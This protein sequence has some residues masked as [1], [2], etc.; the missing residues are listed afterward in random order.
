MNRRL[1][2]LLALCALIGC[3]GETPPAGTS[4]GGTDA[5]GSNGGSTTGESGSDGSSSTGSTTGTSSS[6]TSGSTTASSTATASS[7]G[8][9]SASSASGSSGRSSS[10]GSSASSSTAASSG[11]SGRSSSSSS[12][13]AGSSGSSGRSSSSGSTGSGTTG[14]SSGSSGGTGSTGC[15]SESNATFCSRLNR[16]C[17]SHTANDNCGVRRTVADCGSCTGTDVCSAGVCSCPGETNTAFCSRVGA[18]CGQVS[19]TDICG[20][21]RT[22][23]S[24]GSCTSP[25]SCGG[26]G[27]ANQCG[28]TAE[29]DAEFCTAKGKACG[30]VAGT[31]RCGR[32]RNITDCGACTSP[33][34]CGGGTTPGQC[35]CTAESNTTFCARV[36]ATCGAVTAADNCG[37]SRTVTSC[38]SCTSPATCDTQSHTCGCTGQTDAELCATAGRGC[39]ALTTT[40]RCGATRTIA[41]CGS[42]DPNSALCGTRGRSEGVCLARTPLPAQ[43]VCQTTTGLCWKAPAPTPV[44]VTDVHTEADGTAWA[45]SGNTVI[46]WDGTKFRGFDSVGPVNAYFAAV[47][48]NGPSDV[49]V[50]GSR[51]LVMHFDGTV[52]EDLSPGLLASGTDI[53]DVTDLTGR[54]SSEVWVVGERRQSRMWNGTRW[55][56]PIG[57]TFTSTSGTYRQVA[58]YSPTELRLAT[59]SDLLSWN[60]TTITKI[61]SISGVQHLA[62]G[63]PGELWVASSTYSSST[64]SYRAQLSKYVGGTPSSASLP[65][66]GLANGSDLFVAPRA[67]D[68]IWLLDTGTNSWQFDGNAWRSA[69][70]T[71][72]NTLEQFSAASTQAATSLACTW[73]GGWA[74][75]TSAGWSRLD[76]TFFPPGIT[77]RLETLQ[78]VPLSNGRLAMT[79][80]N[81]YPAP[82]TLPRQVGIFDG[83]NWTG[84][85]NINSSLA[86]LGSTDG[87]TLWLLEPDSSSSG[88]TLVSFFN[89]TSWAQRQTLPGRYFYSVAGLSSTDVWAGGQ[90]TIAHYPAA[91]GGWAVVGNPF[92]GTTTG[93]DRLTP[94]RADLVF[95]RGGNASVLKWAG[96]SWAVDVTLPSGEVYDLQTAPGADVYAAGA[97]GLQRYS[98]A[99]G[100]WSS[101]AVP[102]D[103]AQLG[104]TLVVVSDSDISVAAR[105]AGSAADSSPGTLLHWNGTTWSRET[106]P[107]EWFGYWTLGMQD[108]QRFAYRR[109]SG[110]GYTTTSFGLMR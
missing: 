82:S 98:V 75:R 100:T 95:A 48:S 88:T 19:G 56:D 91:D 12:S 53:P 25:A 31:D 17:G 85:K 73:Q 62:P 35:G 8:A 29:T 13:T 47:W 105:L 2:L 110:Y 99:N 11:S 10:S 68:D 104:R 83:T 69:P 63:N 6:T 49:W 23:S 24:C 15:V 92:S 93:V 81:G 14:A 36:G 64:S 5:A 84:L 66:N 76:T 44:N 79:T 96:T 42:C 33:L 38:G 74:K 70:V 71:G 77:G 89:G 58:V 67:N 20:Q 87:T 40:D 39:G 52:W 57:S 34:T 16:E 9:T 50:G 94:K 37:T 27:T 54:S 51:G 30:P 106:F 103:V 108:G 78:V 90:G 32:T 60:G 7:S 18:A 21:A 107:A 61:D 80:E 65:S 55:L 1:P 102:S 109:Y 46:H 101:I 86:G 72:F 26:A 3:G 22:V 4:T 28:C 59:N 97:F 41:S 43:G 45:V